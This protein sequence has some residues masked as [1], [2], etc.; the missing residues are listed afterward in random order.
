MSYLTISLILALILA[1]ALT[2]II[3]KKLTSKDFR[4]QRELDNYLRKNLESH[5]IGR[6]YERYIGHLYESQGFDVTYNGALNG[7]EDLGRDLIV[8]LNNEFVV[9]QTKCWAK[10]KFIRENAVFQ[11][12]GTMTHFKLT[13]HRRDHQVK[14]I[15]Y[16]TAKYSDTAK[17]VARV[18]GIQL[19]NERLD[20][21][22]PMIKCSIS[23]NGEKL[24]YLPFD[25]QYDK[26]K[27]NP[28]KEETFAYT[29]K[30]AVGK[31]FKRAG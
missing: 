23:K 25:N 27:V 13:T 19:K 12:F 21:T 30:E 6:L 24:F 4:A 26:I 22:Y 11:L 7:Y 2:F 1:L 17:N 20:S 14:A 9:I 16:T 29:V 31:G 8:S 18:L 10:D 15:I 5:E 3:Y 28:N